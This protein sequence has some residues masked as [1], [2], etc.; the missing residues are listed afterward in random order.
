[1]AVDDGDWRLV[2]PDGGMADR[3]ALA[4]HGRLP[5]LSTGDHTLSVRAVDASGNLAQR[6]L[7]VAV[8]APR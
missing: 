2:T 4:F 6:A 7:R 1:V 8:P 5:E 3:P